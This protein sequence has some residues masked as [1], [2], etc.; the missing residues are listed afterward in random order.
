MSFFEGLKG[1]KIGKEI[2]KSLK[3][4]LDGLKSM[5]IKKY[6]DASSKFIKAKK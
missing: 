3:Y 1:T 2:P 5:Y 4:F 6:K